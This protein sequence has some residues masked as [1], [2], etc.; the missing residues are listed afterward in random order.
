MS[1]PYLA[2]SVTGIWLLEELGAVVLELELGVLEEF[3]LPAAGLV[4]ASVDEE[5]DELVLL[6]AVTEVSVVVEDALGVV[7]L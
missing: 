6:G 3:M 1:R 4:L 7:V 5:V 2:G